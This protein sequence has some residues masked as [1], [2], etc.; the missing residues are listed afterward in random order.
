MARSIDPELIPRDVRFIAEKLQEAG[1]AGWVVGGCVRDLLMGRPVSD[2]DLATTAHPKDVQRIFR[3]TIPTGIKHGT[4]SVMLERERYELTTLRGEGAYSDGRRPDSVHFVGTIEEDLARRDFTLNAI[5]WD[6]LTHTLVDP[7]GGVADLEA[8]ILRAV[9]DP[10]ERFSED[11][12]RALRAARFTATLEL[13]LDP[14]TEAAIPGALQTFAKVSPERVLAEWEKAMNAARPSRAFR[15]MHRT[16]M[17]AQTAPFLGR[18]DEAAT[19][20]ALARVDAVRPVFALRIAALVRETTEPLAVVGDWLRG[21]RF[22]NPDR[23]RVL[24]L[25]EGREFPFAPDLPAPARRR[26]LKRF[27][28]DGLFALLDLASADARVR[29]APD[30]AGSL[31]PLFQSDLDRGVALSTK[32]LAITGSDLMTEL[33]MPPSRELGNL[34][35]ALLEVVLDDPSLNERA[36]LLGRAVLLRGARA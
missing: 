9:R 25:I 19:Q 10:N 16:G 8:G 2:W 13:D 14:A 4:V 5:A 24:L 6:P 15:V 28:P 1:F 33:K 11:G 20:R 32:D 26:A 31:P 22:K 27:T 30:V 34:L 3:R 23:E 7:W 17:L 18:L 21:L 29:G 12:L 36:T 35:D